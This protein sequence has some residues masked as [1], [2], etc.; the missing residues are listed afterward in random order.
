MRATPPAEDGLRK[1]MLAAF[2]EI[3][4]AWNHRV[5]NLPRFGRNHLGRTHPDPKAA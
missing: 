4:S 2:T 1:A 3:L 5:R